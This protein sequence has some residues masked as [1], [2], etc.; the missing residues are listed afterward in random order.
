MKMKE[1]DKRVFDT[2]TILNFGKHKGFSIQDIASMDYQYLIWMYENFEDTEWTNGSLQ[3]IT[4]AYDNEVI[5]RQF[6]R[7]MKEFLDEDEAFELGFD[8]ADYY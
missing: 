7:K 3:L 6:Y 1:M 2:N 8:Q 4:E 5:E